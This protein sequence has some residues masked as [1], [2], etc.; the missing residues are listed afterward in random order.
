MIRRIIIWLV[1]VAAAAE[2]VAFVLS[3]IAS[4]SEWLLAVAFTPALAIIVFRLLR[5]P[6]GGS[7]APAMATKQ[8]PDDTVV[9][10]KHDVLISSGARREHTPDQSLEPTRRRKR[11]ERPI[12][13][14]NIAP[15]EPPRRRHVET[16]VNGGEERP[17]RPSQSGAGI[18][19]D[20]APRRR[21]H[22]EPEVNGG[23]DAPNRPSQSVTR[24]DDGE[25]A[26]WLGSILW[27]PPS[28]MRM[29]NSERI[30]VRLGDT[31][32]AIEA[33]CA[34][35]RGRSAPRIDRLEIAPLM[36]VALTADPRD[37]A[38]QA[39]S[40]Q[41][42]FVRQGTVARWDFNVTALRAGLRRLRV[43]ALMRVRVE[44]KDDVVDLPSY[45]SE[46]RVSVA[47]VR[48]VGHFCA[49]NWKWIAGTVAIP[50]LVWAARARVSVTF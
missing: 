8:E 37:F 12:D 50:L 1:I 33:L 9:H 35:L 43:L 41:D 39:L 29:G 46:V 3:S 48:A 42:Q 19:R 14:P 22:A 49:E 27:N 6:R 16:V 7:P 2:V 11:V 30:E 18:E 13:E 47:P 25:Q 23:G 26:S 34:G 17:N 44:G 4:G 38:V 10:I 36:R 28:Q 15:D 21:Q 40:T 20:E 32:Q 31:E 45:E 5:R 24:I